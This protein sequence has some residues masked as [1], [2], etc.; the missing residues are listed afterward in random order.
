M[1][2]QGKKC[3]IFEFLVICLLRGLQFSF[4]DWPGP[5][6]KIN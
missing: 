2:G 5:V 4:A 3:Y 6:I 1:C